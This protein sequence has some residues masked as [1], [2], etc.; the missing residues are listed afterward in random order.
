MVRVSHKRITDL[1][2]TADSGTTT[3]E[4]GQ[5]FEELICYIFNKVPGI[6]VT[7]RNQQNV[8]R[9]EE[10]DIAF[11]NDKYKNGFHF[12]P[13]IILVE[14]KNWSNVVGSIEVSWFYNKLRSRGIV[15]GILIATNGITGDSGDLTAAHSII[16]RALSEGHQL[17]VINRN[18]IEQIISSEGIV[19]LIKEK[20]CDLAVKGTI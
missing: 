5:S 1:L 10:I 11:W 15:F 14:C 6:I 13:H 17:I 7:R 18:E 2:V 12:L 16:A 20:L 9:T 8:F 19:R 4:K 3:T